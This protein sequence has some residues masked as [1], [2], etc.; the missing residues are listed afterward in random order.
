MALIWL[1]EVGLAGWAA[2]DSLRY[3]PP[4]FVAAGKWNKLAWSIMLGLGLL[5]ILVA[6]PIT[7]ITEHPAL[8]P[9]NLPALFGVVAASV[10]LA[11]VRPALQQTRGR[12]G[13]SGP[14]GPW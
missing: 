3:G 12:G 10:Y 4:A 6:C 11:D 7:Q 9:I 13:R 5:F 2:V 8:S 1:V 14:Y